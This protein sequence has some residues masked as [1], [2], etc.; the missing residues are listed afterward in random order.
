MGGQQPA[1][2]G[3]PNQVPD[4][5]RPTSLAAFLLLLAFLSPHVL[6]QA[7][8]DHLELP[9]DAG[10]AAHSGSYALLSH[11]VGDLSLLLAQPGLLVDA[12]GG[13]K[14]WD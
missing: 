1:L 5:G 3:V 10:G 12:A 11:Q 6:L 8:V 4:R 13:R 7:A 2:P 9:L 14:R